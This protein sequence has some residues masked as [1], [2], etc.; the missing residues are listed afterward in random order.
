M[1]LSKK[2]SVTKCNEEKESAKENKK[3][4]ERKIKYVTKGKRRRMLA[5]YSAVKEVEQGE[6]AGLLCQ[7]VSSEC[8]GTNWIIR[9]FR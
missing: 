9:G 2:T 8:P 3:K 4:E 1:Q 7:K 6:A 5:N